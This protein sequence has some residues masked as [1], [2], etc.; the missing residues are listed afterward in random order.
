MALNLLDDETEIQ[1]R[2]EA[3]G[4]APRHQT[5]PHIAVS[6]A[7]APAIAKLTSVGKTFGTSSA[8]TVAIA[9]VT[10]V[11]MTGRQVV[12]RAR[13]I[14]PDLAVVYVSSFTE[15]LASWMVIPPLVLR[16]INPR[17]AA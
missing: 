9:D 8:A 4:L 5:Y 7:A 14:H 3:T 12:E 10:L 17:G 13:S 2:T 16:A 15:P 1:T 6:S 11:G